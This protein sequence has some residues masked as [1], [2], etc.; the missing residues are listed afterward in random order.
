MDIILVLSYVA[1]VTVVFKIFKVPVTKWTVTTAAFGGFLLL[2]WIYISMAYFHPFTPYGKEYF[3]TTPLATEVRGK[4]VEVYVNDNKPLKKGDPIFKVD[5]APY[6]SKVKAL[7]AQIKLAQERVDEQKTLFKKKLGRLTELQAQEA[8]LE[9]LQ[10]EM[11]D[12][13][14]DLNNTIVVA[15]TDGHLIQ[16]RITVGTMAGI[17]KISSLVTF[18]PD[19]KSYFIGAFKSNGISNIKVG[20]RAEV[21][22]VAKPGKIFKARVKRVWNSIEEGQ[23][24]PTAQ[25]INFSKEEEPGRIPVELETLDDITAHNIPKGSAFGVAVYSTHLEF[26][27]VL[28]TILLHMVSWKNILNFEEI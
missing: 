3:I 7:E 15:P 10:A 13:K 28:R 5:P 25:M 11:I 17:F 26:L 27:S 1:L 23:L 12:A 24:V 8:K 14:N 6:E 19:N 4:V 21:Y 18:V 22:F 16:N 20:A 9:K 2:A